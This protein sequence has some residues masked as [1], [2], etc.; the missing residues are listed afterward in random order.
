[1]KSKQSS[2]ICEDLTYIEDLTATNEIKQS[3]Y[4][5]QHNNKRAR[6]SK[7][8]ESSEESVPPT[9][10]DDK[11]QDPDY[12]VSDDMSTPIFSMFPKRK[13]AT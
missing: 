5:D 2:N 8:D 13:H 10:L 4:N 6:M 11:K 9:P 7:V 12:V 3:E 1:M